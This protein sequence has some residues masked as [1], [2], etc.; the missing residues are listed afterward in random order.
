VRARTRVVRA[1]DVET[2]RLP[3]VGAVMGPE[4]PITWLP[5]LNRGREGL[6]PQGLTRVVTDTPVTTRAV[7]KATRESGGRALEALASPPSRHASPCIAGWFTRGATDRC[8]AR[9]PRRCVSPGCRS[10]R[11]PVAPWEQLGARPR[12]D[13]GP[14]GTSDRLVTGCASSSDHA[15]RTSWC[16]LSTLPVLLGACTSHARIERRARVSQPGDP[17]RAS[18]RSPPRWA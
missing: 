9:W 8:G 10:S 5:T 17:Q 4:G 13:R 2:L 1:D 6:E 14:L 3:L 18:H 16:C 11:R 15:A 7:A 12:R